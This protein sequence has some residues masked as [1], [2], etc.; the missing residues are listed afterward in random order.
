VVTKLDVLDSLAEIP[1]CTGYRIDGKPSDTIP[2]DVN[3]FERIEPVY[4]KLPGWKSSTE[5]I[6][7]FEKLPPAAQKYLRFLESESGA[8]IGMVSTGPD[9][10]QTILLP[11]FSGALEWMHSETIQT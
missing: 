7:E 11:D 8:R 10:E 2:A 4:S 3:G 6:T 5:G 9:R 1:I